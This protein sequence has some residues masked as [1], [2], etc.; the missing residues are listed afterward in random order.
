MNKVVAVIGASSDRSKFG[1]KAVR[2]FARQGYTVVPIHPKE[3]SVEGFK[4]YKSVLDVPGPIDMAS[5]YLAPAIGLTVIDDIA[6][7]GIAEVWLNPGADTRPRPAHHRRLQ[8][9]WRRR[10]PARAVGGHT[11][12]G[13]R[14]RAPA[15]N[16]RS[17]LCPS[18]S[19]CLR[20]PACLLTHPRCVLYSKGANTQS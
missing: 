11:R 10:E 8:Y 12:N 18:P 4:A 1:N 16:Q 17:P 19:A 9:R 2:A 15:R 3:E 6:K 7:K 5:M 14:F 20:L 13:D